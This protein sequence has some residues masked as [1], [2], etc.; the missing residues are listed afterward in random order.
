MPQLEALAEEPGELSPDKW[1]RVPITDLAYVVPYEDWFE[2]LTRE[3]LEIQHFKAKKLKTEVAR[4]YSRVRACG[5]RVFFV[6]ACGAC[7]CHIS[8]HTFYHCFS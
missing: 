4:K 2:V 7:M 1:R 6:R 3:H 8:K 5:G